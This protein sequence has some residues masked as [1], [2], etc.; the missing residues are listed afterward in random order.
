MNEPALNSRSRDPA[1]G[2]PSLFAF[3]NLSLRNQKKSKSIFIHK[4]SNHMKTKYEFNRLLRSGTLLAFLF[5]WMLIGSFE[6][7]AQQSSLT[8]AITGVGQVT[9]NVPPAY[10]VQG[11]VTGSLLGNFG[12]NT[13][14][15]LTATPAPGWTFDS[16]SGATFN[17]NATSPTATF[18]LT[19]NTTITASFKKM[20][21]L[22]GGPNANNKVYDGNTSATIG[23]W[24]TLAGIDPLYP[25]VTL[26]TGGHIA[27]FDNKNVGNNKT[28]TI[29]G[30]SLAGA[31]APIYF[32]PPSFT[33]QANITPLPITIGGVVTAN[34]KVFDNTTTATVDISLA[35]LPGVI[36]PDV[37]TLSVT[38]ADFND[39][40]AGV[41]K[42]VTVVYS[43]GGADAGNY[44]VIAPFPAVTA[45][46]TPKPIFLNN[47]VIQTKPYDGTTTATITSLGPITGIVPPGTGPAAVTVS[48]GT[49]TFGDPFVGTGK[50][51]NVSG[52][53]VSNANYILNQPFTTTGTITAGVYA[54]FNPSYGIV[55]PRPV[56]P[57]N[58]VPVNEPLWIEFNQPVV[59][60]NNAPLPV[61]SVGDF[62]K[63]EIWNTG[64]L[65]WD[66]V[67]FSSNRV[68]NKINIIP[69]SQ[70]AYSTLYRIR[71]LNVYK[72]PAFGGGQVVYSL[73]KG[74]SGFDPT[75]SVPFAALQADPNR[76]VEFNTMSLLTATLPTV[77]PY[78]PGK[79]VCDQI[80]LTFVNPVKYL[81]GSDIFDNPKH[82]FTLEESTD[83]GVTWN[84]VP[85]SDWDVAV[86]VLGNPKEFT[87][88]Y[89]PGPLK[90]NTD[91][92]IVNNVGLDLNFGFIDK[93]TTFN[94]LNGPINYAHTQGVNGWNWTTVPTYPLIVDV[95]PWPQTPVFPSIPLPN[96]ASF[97]AVPNVTV[98]PPPT[99]TL[100]KTTAYTANVTLTYPM[101]AVDGEGYHWVNWS[102][103]TNGG[104]T[105]TNL[106]TTGS[107]TV[108]INF[109][110]QNW[111]YNGNALK[112]TTCSQQIGYRANFEINKYNITTTVT[113]NV[114]WGSVTG[115]ANNINHGSTVN[116]TATPAPGYYLVGWN[117]AALPPSVAGTVVQNV[118]NQNLV[119]YPNFI[120]NVGT[121][122][123]QLVGPLTHNTTWNIQAIFAPFQP[124]LYAA[125]DPQNLNT[126]TVNITKEFGAPPT[127]NFGTDNFQAINYVWEQYNF[128][129]SVSLHA[130]NADCQYV[131]VKWQIWNPVLGGGSWVDYSTS[132]PTAFFPVNANMRIKA[133]YKLKDDVHI[134]AIGKI[135]TRGT[136]V[137]FS[138]PAR[139]NIVV[140]GLAEQLINNLNGAIFTYGTPLYI[141]T[142]NEPD[143]YSWKWEDA[144]GNA[145]PLGT[146]PGQVQLN[147]TFPD[148]RE[149]TYVVGCSNVDLKMVF[150]LKEYTVI[151]RT[152]NLAQ[153]NTNLSTPA[154]VSGTGYQGG[155][156]FVFTNVP[157]GRKGE[158]F[159]QRNSSVTFR[160]TP[161]TNWAFDYWELGD[162]NGNPTGVVVS[163]NA[164]YTIASLQGN[165]ELIARF[166]ST[167]PPP[168]TYPLTVNV[169]PANAGTTTVTSGNY[170]PGPITIQAIANPGWTFANWTA[171]GVTLTPAQ[172]TANPMTFTMPAGPVT[173]TANFVQTQYTLTPVSR[174]YILPESNF[175]VVNFGGTVARIPA[176][177]TFTAGQTVQLSATPNPGFSFVNWMVGQI[178]D[179]APG[180][181]LI[182]RG[183]QIS[184]QPNFTYTIPALPGNPPIYVYAI[185]VQTAS[186]GYSIYTLNTVANPSG[187]GTVTGAGMYAHGIEVDVAQSVTQPGYTFSHWSPNVLPGNYVQMNMSQ[188]AVANYVP[189]VYTL[190]VFTNNPAWGTVS[191]NSSTFT[192]NDSPIPV[193]ALV[194]FPTCDE[195]YVFQ[196]WYTDPGLTT[197][198][199]DA[200]NN[201]VTSA[202]FNFI[203]FALT[204]PALTY[205][206]YAKFAPV[207]NNYSVTANVNIPAAG[208]VSVSPAGPYVNNQTVVISTTP[209]PGYQFQ[210][211]TDGN[212]F[213][214]QLSFNHT[215]NCANSAFTAVYVPI[216]YTVTATAGTGGTV[217]PASQTTNVNQTVTVVATPN[218]GWEFAGWTGT[219]ITLPAPPHP[220]TLNFT[221]PANN[222]TLNASFTKIVYTVTASA[223]TGGSVSPLTQNATI[224]DAVTVTATPNAGYTFAGWTATGVTLTPSQTTSATLNFTMPAGN[225]TLQASF[226]PIPYTVT[227]TA[228]PSNG[229]TFSAIAPNYTVGQSVTV[230]A[231]ANSGFVFSGWTATGITLGT[232]ANATQTFNMPANNVT[233]TAN[234]TAV[235]N[236]IM[237]QVRYFNQFESGLPFSA[238]VKV[239]LY[240]GLNLVGGPV[241]LTTNNGFSGYYEFTGIVPGV[242]YTLRVMEDDATLGSSWGWNNWGGVSAADALIASYMI[243]DNPIVE[244]FPWIAPVTVLNQ[245]AFAKKVADVNGSNTLTS[246]D[247]LLMMYRS[248]GLP[249]YSLYPNNVPNFQV[250][251]GAVSALGVKT[252]PQAPSIVFASNGTYAA[253][254]PGNAFYYTGNFV[255]QAGN[256]VMNIYFI[257]SGDV[258]ASYVPAGGAKKAMNLN[259][260]GVLNAKAGEV[261]RIPVRLSNVTELGAYNLGINFNNQLIKVLDVEGAEVVNVN[262][263]NGTVRVAWMDRNA[264]S[265]DNLV[266]LVAEVLANIPADVR[267]MEL[268]ATTELADANAQTIEGVELATVA[269]NGSTANTNE[270]SSL[271]LVAFPNPFNNIATLSYELPEAGKVSIVVY[272]KLGQAVKTLVNEVKTAGAHTVQL[273][274]S[275][276][277]G[278]GAY[279]Y[280]ITV[281]GN[282]RTYT[283]N[284]TLILVK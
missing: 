128:N 160:A 82:K 198:L 100:T 195:T 116:L 81:N 131:F 31:D 125:T 182:L 188:T 200:G 243:A 66:A 89:H 178:M 230:T 262:N 238:N 80:K 59:D 216:N 141:T 176:T 224:G 194:N 227:L 6:A 39:V 44:T 279:I 165:V 32:L 242:T 121:L 114:A 166:V 236:K 183:H 192:V 5:A 151:S 186:P 202:N 256:T 172:Q 245:T 3:E 35:T 177:G 46:I 49:A 244:N 208:S 142:Y 69:T 197:P 102:R 16:W 112:P 111:T 261:V 150:D 94:L 201:P 63:L 113:P 281:E 137:V 76:A 20:L 86:D 56:A 234:F 51:V 161:A 191:P 205:N 140:N 206:L 271:S 87:F 170:L 21:T 163:T 162:G 78:G 169:T 110:P 28:V 34:N 122:S 246:V 255:G 58:N 264:R 70:L 222:V 107:G 123:F 174:T 133:V 173:L 168:P 270:V 155:L 232:P 18:V 189:I 92:R 26:N 147:G 138:D 48:G 52:V 193:S 68:G 250:A 139:T 266:V 280:R 47:V 40:N 283:S 196:G 62:V 65:T 135:A 223:G 45:N 38:S 17:P 241:S 225:V 37:V 115:A 199:L 53:V 228:V 13:V 97:N 24:G 233:L 83:G 127:L 203:P 157:P 8:V 273:N 77:T 159:F 23:S 67:P 99:Y 73:D 30:L 75:I 219:G 258:N 268:D 117:F 152:L 265:F 98:G 2:V 103:T 260:N 156:G 118:P 272:N 74:P 248:V 214:T 187:F 36:P 54:M 259:Y 10:Q 126:G 120:S 27:T 207:V 175:T 25:N 57:V 29:T 263:E 61:N 64:T 164:I 85:A 71:F 220:A 154:F 278:N 153:G 109:A 284:G 215:I 254:T 144:N 22:T 235:N 79:G 213:I 12:N 101:S 90:F 60:I 130:V 171:T 180:P 277:N 275:D 124:K 210:H 50:T 190:N 221:M 105:W 119:G 179:P 72:T 149:W 84:P 145:I 7:K 9:V 104:T 218:T 274:A 184:N 240:N 181:E 11:P 143:Y 146:N 158:G 136:V 217:A 249:G 239:A 212:L 96:F 15:T 204:P 282:A 226:N 33:A 247:P 134:S 231:T 252:Y 237:G 269:I 257:A 132:N 93:V 209:N 251:A 129:T 95:A 1:V 185:F 167:L 108:G 148:R 229:G 42:P 106:P 14:I 253:G 276:L 55:G 19:A 88:T 43:L 267:Y 4:I 91:Y 41:N 211:W